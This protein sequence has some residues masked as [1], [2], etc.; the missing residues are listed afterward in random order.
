[1]FG[2]PAIITHLCYDFHVH[3]P[4]VCVCACAHS[5]RTPHA[6]QRSIY[7]LANMRS[8]RARA[9]LHGRP[10]PGS[11]SS[12]TSKHAR[13][14]ARSPAGGSAKFIHINLPSM[15]GRTRAR[16]RESELLMCATRAFN[17]NR[18]HARARIMHRGIV[19][20][21]GHW[22]WAW[23]WSGRCQLIHI[24]MVENVLNGAERSSAKCAGASVHHSHLE[25]NHT[26]PG[27]FAAAAAN[28]HT[29]RHHTHTH[30]YTH[31]CGDPNGS[32]SGGG[33]YTNEPCA[34]VE[35]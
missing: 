20:V 11:S 19:C 33:V 3:A 23:A 16:A 24:F 34:Y 4:S 5:L 26:R 1:M 22:A 35:K 6:H 21:P 10:Q 17:A 31:N 12:T 32:G 9:V 25:L 18:R 8:A 29:V 2:M 15:S 13:T 7:K 30:T 14:H 27:A 28:C